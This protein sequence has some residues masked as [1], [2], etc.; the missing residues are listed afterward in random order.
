[1]DDARANLCSNGGSREELIEHHAVVQEEFVKKDELY[2]ELKLTLEVC[3]F[4]V[5][6]C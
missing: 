3:H 5:S 6:M 2:R 4:S 1:M